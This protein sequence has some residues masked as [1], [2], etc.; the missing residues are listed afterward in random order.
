MKKLT[1]LLALLALLNVTYS[2]Q[3]PNLSPEDEVSIKRI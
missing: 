3:I 2:L 1:A